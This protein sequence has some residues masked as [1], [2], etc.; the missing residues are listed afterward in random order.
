M[1]FK[2]LGLDIDGTLTNTKKEITPKVRE[3]IL[4]IQKK[5]IPVLLVSGRPTEGIIPIAKML[6]MEEFGGYILAFNGGKIIDAKTKE[7]IY[8]KHIPDEEIHNIWQFAKTNELTILTYRHGKI[9]TNNANNE[10][11]EIESRINK[12]ETE[13]VLDFEAELVRPCDKFLIVG[14]PK[15]MEEKVK[16]MQELFLGRLNIFRSEPF[17]IE[18]VP[19]GID[20]A[21]SL[22]VLLEKIGCTKEELVACGDGRNDVTMVDYAGMGVAM[23]NACEEVKA[24]AN[25][26]TKSNDQD[27]VALAIERY[28]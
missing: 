15:I 4:E 8:N 10:Y 5:G 24:V 13:Q 26:I 6:D 28:F 3:A 25:F 14:D 2:I 18:I 19:M 9:I 7:V 22:S 17:F 23:E 1:N 20:K 12:M 16:E 27:G 21:Q 11:V